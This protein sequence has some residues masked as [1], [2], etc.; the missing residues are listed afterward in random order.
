MRAVSLLLALSAL[1][2]V[3]GGCGSKSKRLTKAE[4]V[5]RANAI[6][7][8]YEQRVQRRM[9]GIPPG[10]E[11]QLA[12]SIEKVLPVIR[13][14]NDELRSLKPPEDLQGHYDRWMRIAD[15][16]VAA[17]SKLQDALHKGDRQ[18]IQAAFAELQTKDVDQDRLAR[19]ELGLN[20]CASG[21]SG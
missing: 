13:D 2:L 16:E 15:A 11:K 12:S 21:S 7:A 5:K 8:T 20:G 14:G 9:A 10:D 3:A 19:Q 18:A 4:F 17:A 6:C 1:A